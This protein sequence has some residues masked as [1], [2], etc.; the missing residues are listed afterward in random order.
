MARLFSLGLIAIGLAPAWGQA[1]LLSSER[2]GYGPTEPHGYM[3]RIDP[4]MATLTHSQRQDIQV[5]VENAQGKPADGV[6]VHFRPSEGKVTSKPRNG[7]TRD[8]VVQGTFVPA[9][10]SDQPRTAYVIVTVENVE[11]TLFIDIVPAVFGR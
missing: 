1:G 10:G 2:R 4:Q 5:M 11:V 9:V 6:E 8:G 7:K 3:V